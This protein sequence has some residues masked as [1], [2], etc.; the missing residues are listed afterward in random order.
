M[1]YN[2]VRHLGKSLLNFLVLVIGFGFGFF[3]MHHGKE[4]ENFE[5][6]FKAIMKTLTMTLGEFDFNVR[7]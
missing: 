4:A 1:F 5:N 2:I 3:I 7:R 6:P